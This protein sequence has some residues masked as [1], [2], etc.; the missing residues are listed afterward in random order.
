MVGALQVTTLSYSH[1]MTSKGFNQTKTIKTK[2]NNAILGATQPKPYS[3]T[4]VYT[5]RGNPFEIR[6]YRKRFMEPSL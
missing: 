6:A 2:D 4:R 3:T 5:S 1:L